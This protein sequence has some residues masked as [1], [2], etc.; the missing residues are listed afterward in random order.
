V[1]SSTTPVNADP[2]RSQLTISFGDIIRIA[3]LDG[4]T[5]DWRLT[6]T[7]GEAA[8]EPVPSLPTKPGLYQVVPRGTSLGVSRR[9]MLSTDGTWN[10][11]D[12][13]CGG[14]MQP[15]EISSVADYADQLILV[16]S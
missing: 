6:V 8:L 7:R 3:E 4:S 11:V 2:R 5:T 10:W 13:S 14:S 12:F 16:Y 15:A 1:P 9:L